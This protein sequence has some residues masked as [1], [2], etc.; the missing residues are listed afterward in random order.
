MAEVAGG[1]N[2]AGIQQEEGRGLVGC[3][4]LGE[5]EGMGRGGYRELGEKEGEECQDGR[6]RESVEGAW[7]LQERGKQGAGRAV[8]LAG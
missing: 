6:E 5:K 1:A 7:A 4:E 2:R 3:R 8:C